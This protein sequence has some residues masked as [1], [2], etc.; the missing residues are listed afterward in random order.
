MLQ[1]ERFEQL[2]EQIL[3]PF[4]SQLMLNVNWQKNIYS[5]F[6]QNAIPALIKDTSS[7]KTMISVS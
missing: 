4:I 7:G 1:G 6:P 2:K 5:H 3:F